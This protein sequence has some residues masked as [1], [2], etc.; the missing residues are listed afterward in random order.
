MASVKI[1]GV[2]HDWESASITGPHGMFIDITEINWKASQKKKR[3]YGKGN[4]SIGYTRGNYSAT[5][6]L[7]IGKDEFNQLVDSL[8]I[9]ILK[10]SPFD[11]V[12]VTEPNDQPKSETTIRQILVD[13]IDDS[14]KNGEDAEMVKLSGSAQMITRNGVEDYE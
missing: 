9:S 10:A 13:D 12:V 11:I 8:G 6:D 2:R 4:V 14:L 7:T 3:V 5:V 1:N